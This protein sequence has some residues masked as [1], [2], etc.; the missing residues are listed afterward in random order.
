MVT[1]DP[2]NEIAH[3][4]QLAIAP[5]FL[6]TAIAGLLNVLSQRL[7]RI[8]DRMRVLIDLL[9]TSAESKHPRIRLEYRLL[10][11]RRHTANIAIACGTFA[12]LLVC[13]L[14]ASAFTGFLF[15]LDVASPLAVLFVMAMLALIGSLS[16]FLREVF[17]AS[18][19]THMPAIEQ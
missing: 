7:G 6:L 16:F 18:R 5:V 11:Y 1:P 12:A 4:I 9:E 17:F 13:L 8:V 19:S 15:K 3:T 2:T 14:I 10:T